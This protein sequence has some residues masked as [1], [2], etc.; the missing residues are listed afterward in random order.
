MIIGTISRFIELSPQAGRAVS[1]KVID[2]Q[3]RVMWDNKLWRPLDDDAAIILE[4]FQGIDKKK[5]EEFKNKL[6]SDKFQQDL[7]KKLGQTTWKNT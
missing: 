1:P 2:T 4:C 5:M 7:I 6:A 3:W